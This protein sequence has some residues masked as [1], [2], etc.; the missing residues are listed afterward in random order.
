MGDRFLKLQ[1]MYS[2]SQNVCIEVY[3]ILITS[4]T[5]ILG[6]ECTFRCLYQPLISILCI[7]LLSFTFENEKCFIYT[8]NYA[9]NVLR[10]RMSSI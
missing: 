5:P 3:G 1:E 10:T 9:E 7:L 6:V 2:F 8:E 4:L